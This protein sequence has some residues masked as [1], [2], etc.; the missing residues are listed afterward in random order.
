MWLAVPAGALAHGGQRLAFLIDAQVDQARFLAWL[1]K[2]YGAELVEH[3]VA[4][5]RY[6]ARDRTAWA[7]IDRHTLLY[8]H[9]DFIEEVLRAAA[10]QA[11]TA[12]DNADLVRAAASARSPGAHAW[13]ALAVPPTL[14]ARLAGQAITATM[15]N[16]DWAAG[17]ISLGRTTRLYGRVRTGDDRTAV[18]LAAGLTQLSHML[19]QGAAPGSLSEALG[20]IAVTS[21]HRD[22]ELAATVGSAAITSALEGLGAP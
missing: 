15:A 8:A 7:F 11:P 2:T 4:G 20:R 6:Y 22:V 5:C 19:G 12:L 14:K 21:D 13:L 9:S 1:K 16:L 3:Q 10:G 18:A 17:R